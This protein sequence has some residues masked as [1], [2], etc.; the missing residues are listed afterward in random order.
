[1]ANITYSIIIPVFNEEES[2]KELLQ[3]IKKSFSRIKKSYEIIFIDDGSF[4]SSLDILKRLEKDNKEIR[5]FSFRR[6]LGKSNALMMGFQQARGEFIV[7]MDADLQD[8]PSNIKALETKLIKGD[9]DM[10]TGWRKDRRDSPYKKITSHIFNNIVSH[11]FAIK[12]HDLN[13]GLKLYRQEV[14]KELHIYGGMHRFI[15]VIVNE[16]GYR[17]AELETL[18]HPRKYGKSKYKAT[19]VITNIPDLLT[20]YFLTKYTRRPLHF[21]GKIGT[22]LFILGIIALG[23][24]SIL[25]LMGQRIGTRPLLFFGMLLII[26]GIQTVFTGLLADLFINERKNEPINFPLKYVSDK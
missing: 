16:L 15:P 13:S 14:V 9:F 7:T 4:D 3:T 6:N 8:D 11:L 1:M 19:K 18:H 12:I 10:V 22:L 26:A 23:Y 20:I 17:V 21:F 2:L 24:L 5:V 25:H